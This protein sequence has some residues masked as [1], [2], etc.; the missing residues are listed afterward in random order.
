MELL[1]VMAVI[2]ILA[3]LIFG[4]Y[5]YVK[6]KGFRSRAQVEVEAL[7]NACGDYKSDNGIYPSN[8]DT[9]KL[10]PTANF[11][12]AKNDYSVYTAASVFLYR[13]LSGDQDGNTATTADDSRNYL[14]A[15]N[16]PTT[17]GTSAAGSFVKDPFGNSYGYSTAKAN[18]GNGYNPTFDLWSTANSTDPNQWIKN[19]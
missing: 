1:V 4:T 13:Q 17:I 8:D 16:L 3:G 6:K 14:G 12:A 11:D 10:D 7:S 18:G 15:L 5:S 19:W 2:A 9:K